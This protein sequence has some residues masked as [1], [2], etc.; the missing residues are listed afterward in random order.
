M[1]NNRW[2][3]VDR[4]M[5]WLH[6]YSG[7]FLVPWMIIYATSAL[8]LNHH[9][10]FVEQ[11]GVTPARWERVRQLDFVPNDSFPRE[12]DQQAVAILQRLDL[13]GPPRGRPT[14]PRGQMIIHRISGGGPYRVIWHR[15]QSRI[16]VQRR[17]PFS[18]YRLMHFLHFRHGYAQR[19]LA[20][21]AWAV[22]VDAVSVCI[23]LWVVSGIDIWARRPKKRLLGGVCLIAGCV[24]FVGLTILM[25]L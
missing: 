23:L 6:L 8:C 3:N 14:A 22:T 2:A 19:D 17:T 25:C 4:W 15:H 18:Y 7:L 24:L 9:K 16:V 12:R 1:G 13:D 21:V 10:W 11:L 20:S 5:R